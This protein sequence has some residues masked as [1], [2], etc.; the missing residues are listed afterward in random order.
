ME[1]KIQ[2]RLKKTANENINFSSIR[3]IPLNSLQVINDLLLESSYEYST[4][5]S[6]ELTKLL[7]NDSEYEYS[8]DCELDVIKELTI[9][10]SYEFSTEF[11]SYSQQESSYEF[12]T[13]FNLEVTKLLSID[14]EYEYSTEFLTETVNELVNDSEYEYSTEFNLELTNLLTNDSEYEY[15]TEFNSY[16]ELNSIVEYSTEFSLEVTRELTNDSEY[17]YNTEFNSHSELNSVLEYSTDFD[18]TVESGSSNDLA[19]TTDLIYST[20]FDYI[21]D[22]EDYGASHWWTATS[23]NLSDNDAVT[24]WTDVISGLTLTANDTPIFKTNILNGLPVVRFDGVNDYFIGSGVG[25]SGNPPKSI[26]IVFR[27]T[28][29]GERTMVFL[30]ATAGTGGSVTRICSDYSYRF[31]NGNR[32][33]VAPSNPSDWKIAAC[34]NAN[35]ASYNQHNMIINNTV[36]T[37]SSSSGAS[38]EPN[39]L[40]Q[41]FTIGAGIGNVG[42]VINYFSGD[43]S[44][45]IVVPNSN[46]SAMLQWFGRQLSSRTGIAW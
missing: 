12:S 21:F 7:I 45:V 27:R 28:N 13:E 38:L 2:F 10:S 14:S 42:T 17:E 8:S 23:L 25:I 15:I 33:F 22:P 32:V 30:G 39:L 6:L 1:N 24:S 40:D 35:N 36:L 9:E 20:Q 43:I 19:F 34:H 5:F 3:F 16:S 31:N 37:Q 11:N 44:D 26:F 29:T 46:Q 18:L 41:T 4:E